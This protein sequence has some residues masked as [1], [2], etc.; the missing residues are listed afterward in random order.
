MRGPGEEIYRIVVSCSY[1]LDHEDYEVEIMYIDA[2]EEL[3]S[4][5]SQA[6]Q[7]YQDNHIEGNWYYLCRYLASTKDTWRK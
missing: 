7:L 1:E 4:W 6:R 5:F 3:Q 2:P